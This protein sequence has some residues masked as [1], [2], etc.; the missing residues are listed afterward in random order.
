MSEHH[1]NLRSRVAGIGSD[2]ALEFALRVGFSAD[3]HAPMVWDDHRN[4]IHVKDDLMQICSNVVAK[5]GPRSFLLSGKVGVGKTG[6]LA[7][8][9]KEV[10]TMEA[11][12]YKGDPAH[13]PILL[14]QKFLLVTHREL[15]DA[16]H[17]YNAEEPPKVVEEDLHAARVLMIDD[18]GTKSV[19][20]RAFNLE[21]FQD[22]IDF[23][24]KYGLP[25]WITSNIDG[26]VWA[27]T[28]GYE[29][30]CS[31]WDDESKS[32]LLRFDKNQIDRRPTNNTD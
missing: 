19:D 30:I 26:P 16:F 2:L 4:V 13:L 29:R 25:V 21:Q 5:A 8:M 11:D 15:V 1:Q 6:C 3:E 7:V 31:R 27:K 32:W 22:L 28:P 14:G 12:R 20:G 18:L 10:F 17:S 23:R 9:A 24:W